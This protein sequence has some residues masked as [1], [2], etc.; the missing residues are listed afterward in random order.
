MQTRARASAIYVKQRALASQRASEQTRAKL[1]LSSEKLG[2][3]QSQDGVLAPTRKPTRLPAAA[4][5]VAP[6]TLR[7]QACRRLT[8]NAARAYQALWQ[9][10]R[11]L[12]S[13]LTVGEASWL[14]GWLASWCKRARG[15]PVRPPARP[16]A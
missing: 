15:A 1:L 8:M 13:P 14:A 6:K 11:P 4:V 7:Y 3:K 9:R 10:V 5:A 16:P 2:P 12:C